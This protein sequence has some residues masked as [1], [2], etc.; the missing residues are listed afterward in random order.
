MKLLYLLVIE[1][2]RGDG[3]R[4]GLKVVVK[5]SI[6]CVYMLKGCDLGQTVWD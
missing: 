4:E 1:L 5:E 6:W 3:W 2:L